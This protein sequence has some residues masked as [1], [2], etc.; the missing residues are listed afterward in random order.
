[1][2]KFGMGK[3]LRKRSPERLSQKETKTTERKKDGKDIRD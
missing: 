2:I 1:M 3:V